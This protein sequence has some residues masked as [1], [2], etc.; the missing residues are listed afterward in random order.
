MPTTS[1]SKT[2]PLTVKCATKS[3]TQN[4]IHQTQQQPTPTTTTDLHCRWWLV[5]S[6]WQ[7]RDDVWFM[8]HREK[9][10]V[11]KK[12]NFY[13]ILKYYANM[14]DIVASCKI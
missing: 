13:T 2:S 8:A 3:K 4:E 12:K 5:Q 9:L 1:E 7:Y 6:V 10:K 11:I 14:H